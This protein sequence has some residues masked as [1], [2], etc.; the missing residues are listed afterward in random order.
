MDYN[1]IT[2]TVNFFRCVIIVLA[3]SMYSHTAQHKLAWIIYNNMVMRDFVEYTG[4][5]PYL[6]F[7]KYKDVYNSN[8]K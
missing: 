6:V 5:T 3:S 7:Y 1:T 2:D 4:T 8:H